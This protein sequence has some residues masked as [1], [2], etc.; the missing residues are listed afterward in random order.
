ME[1]LSQHHLG[2]IRTKNALLVGGGS[3]RVFFCHA[4]IAVRGAAEGTGLQGCQSSTRKFPF[5]QFSFL[6]KQKSLNGQVGRSHFSKILSDEFG[7]TG[8]RLRS[9]SRE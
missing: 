9:Y 6:L 1:A 3:M 7:K 2:Q 4:L 5:Q 8:G